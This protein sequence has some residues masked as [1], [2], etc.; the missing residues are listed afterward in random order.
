MKDSERYPCAGAMHCPSRAGRRYTVKMACSSHSEW[1]EDCKGCKL[2]QVALCDG[3]APQ[4]ARSVI[5]ATDQDTRSP[6]RHAALSLITSAHLD[7]MRRIVSRR[8]SARRIG[9]DDLVFDEAFNSL[10]RIL[11]RKLREGETLSP[12]AVTRLAESAAA[13]SN[14]AKATQGKADAVADMGTVVPDNPYSLEYNADGWHIATF[15]GLPEK[16]QGYLTAYSRGEMTEHDNR[17]RFA[18]GAYL[19]ARRQ[20]D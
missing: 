9:Q 12:V 18:A 13:V 6:Y 1:A 5:R 16:W 17:V 8:C 2:R 14:S 11:E 7:A 20:Q 3:H 4:D 10:Q 15:V 19:R